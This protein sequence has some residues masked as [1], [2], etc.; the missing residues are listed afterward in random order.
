MIEN[1]PTMLAELGPRSHPAH[2]VEGAPF[3]PQ[4]GS[5]F[6]DIQNWIL[7]CFFHGFSPLIVTEV[8]RGEF[9]HGV[10]EQFPHVPGTARE[11]ILRTF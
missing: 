4:E 7:V 1:A 2:V 6:P 9:E 3:E 11:R 5:G 10:T 8:P